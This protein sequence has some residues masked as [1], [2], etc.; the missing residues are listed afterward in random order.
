VT[1]DA[2]TLVAY[3]DGQRF[4]FRG[5]D[6][7]DALAAGREADSVPDAWAALAACGREV[8]EE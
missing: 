1:E 2:R 7:D 6:V 3:V 5:S 8:T 4:V